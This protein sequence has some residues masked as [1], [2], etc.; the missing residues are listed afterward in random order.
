VPYILPQWYYI[1]ETPWGTTDAKFP[2]CD[3]DGRWA[4]ANLDSEMYLMNHVLYKN[5]GSHIQV[6]RWSK[7][8]TTNGKESLG[9]HAKR[10]AEKW[11]KMP[12]VLLVDWYEDGDA[13]AVQDWANGLR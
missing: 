5:L 2:S 1:S 7:S 3:M 6:P 9:G 12:N 13:F 10:C 8:K 4:S 11:G